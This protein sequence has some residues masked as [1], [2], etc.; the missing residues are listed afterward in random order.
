MCPGTVERFAPV[1]VLGQQGEFRKG[2]RRK[3]VVNVLPAQM[4]LWKIGLFSQ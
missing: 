4:K 3:T 2:K 1:E